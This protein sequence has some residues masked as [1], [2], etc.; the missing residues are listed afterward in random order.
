MRTKDV[1]DLLWSKLPDWMDS[2][3]K[4]NK[5]ANI[6]AELRRLGKIKNTGT[7]TKPKWIKV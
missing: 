4:K 2:N 6:L 7:D 1:D 3:Q 5:I